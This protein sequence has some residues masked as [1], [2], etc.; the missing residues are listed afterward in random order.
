MSFVTVQNDRF[1]AKIEGSKEIST[2]SP[3][4]KRLRPSSMTV[5]YFCYGLAFY[6]LGVAAFLESRRDSALQR[7]GDITL[8]A[9]SRAFDPRR[10]QPP[11]L[12]RSPYDVPV[13]VAGLAILLALCL[14]P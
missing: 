5:I 2:I 12:Q 6:T 9:E 14:I 10:S 13:A 4:E 3:K 7:A 1:W 11:P 8:A